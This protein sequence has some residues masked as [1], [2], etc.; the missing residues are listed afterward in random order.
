[1]TDKELEAVHDAIARI[2]IAVSI[3]DTD[4][5]SRISPD[6]M[7]IWGASSGWGDSASVT[8]GD[9]RRLAELSAAMNGGSIEWVQFCSG[10]RN[11]PPEPAATPH[12]S[13]A[14][15]TG[16]IGVD[17]LWPI[18]EPSAT[19]R[20]DLFIAQTYLR[21]LTARYEYVREMLLSDWDGGE[22]LV[23]AVVNAGTAQEFDE[24]IDT[25]I[26]LRDGAPK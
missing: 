21:R 14:G 12:F 10:A 17:H 8:L 1:M 4:S 16:K 18:V 23:A 15:I 13:F 24:V 5:L 9:L 26:A 20:R 6:S 7:A 2:A 11:K 25:A 22:F 3:N 19:L